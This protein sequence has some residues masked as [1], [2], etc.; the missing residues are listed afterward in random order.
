VLVGSVL[1]AL[2]FRAVPATDFTLGDTVTLGALAASAV[3]LLRLL[4]RRV[5][6]RMLG[7]ENVLLIGD[8]PLL[9]VLARKLDA[10]P[11]YGL[12]P[13]GVISPS[14]SAAS[15]GLPVLGDLATFDLRTLWASHGVERIVVSHVTVDEEKLLEV[16]RQCKSLSIKVSLLP[17]LVDALGPSVEIDDVEGLTVLGINP[18]ILSRSSRLLKR[19]MDMVGALCVLAITAPLMVLIAIAIRLNSPGAVLYR[20][21][22]VGKDGRLFSLVKFRT[23]VVDADAQREALL[24]MSKHPAWLLLDHDPRITRVGRRLR[25]SSLDELPQLW[26]VLK[27]E[28]SLVG[29]RPLPPAECAA[30]SGWARSRLDLTPGVTGLWQVLGRTSISYEEMIKL[31][32]VYV[33][34]WSMWNDVRLILRTLPV[35]VS[36]RG[37]N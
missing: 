10:H 21:Q 34:N 28:M 13:V 35:V 5:A 14:P 7:P 26:N 33:T 37:A 18:P 23:M 36:R 20:Q 12:R 31:D 25:L 22:R 4:V 2:Y 3:T 24:A 15:F 32:Y 29:P 17:H 27:G 9:G 8:G 11:E 6:D 1:S 16:I 19:S 30:L